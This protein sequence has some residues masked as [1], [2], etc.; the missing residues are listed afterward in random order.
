MSSANRT[1]SEVER[2][3]L[4]L[5]L[6]QR[7]IDIFN[8]EQCYDLS[9]FLYLEPED[10]TDLG[11]DELEG[12]DPVLWERATKAVLAGVDEVKVQTDHAWELSSMEDGK[13][14]YF[15][16]LTLETR[17][18]RPPTPKRKPRFD[19]DWEAPIRTIEDS[20]DYLSNNTSS[21]GVSGDSSS[22][23]NNNNNNNSRSIGT[24]FDAVLHNP[25]IFED[26][27][28]SQDTRIRLSIPEVQDS[29]VNGIIDGGDYKSYDDEH[30]G[31]V[32]GS[33]DDFLYDF[34]KVVS[35][36][37]S[38]ANSPDNSWLGGG[39]N[40][41][42]NDD[43]ED[44]MGGIED[45]VGEDQVKNADDGEMDQMSTVEMWYVCTNPETGE[46]DGPFS[47][48]DVNDWYIKIG[49]AHV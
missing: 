2:F 5:G 32:T 23:S 9:S 45:V 46:T 49:R 28:W 33:N 25:L 43:G 41:N 26:K 24:Y 16:P 40:K 18:D 30:G 13:Q 14:F 11:V 29:E 44:L 37:S 38:R 39:G 47:M 48:I 20:E 31:V 7:V 21:S 1:N 15:N 36:K 19:I 22:S 8:R 42:D 3:L 35:P 17:W 6:P 34:G 12:V 4:R 27:D 10:L